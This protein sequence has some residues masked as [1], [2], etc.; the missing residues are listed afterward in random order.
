MPLSDI[1]PVT[2]TDPPGILLKRAF[3]AAAQRRTA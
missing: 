1:F 3:D 2:L